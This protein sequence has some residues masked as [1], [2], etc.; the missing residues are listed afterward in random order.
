MTP[1]CPRCGRTRASDDPCISRLPGVVNACCGHGDPLV[2]PY[3][4]LAG[5]PSATVYGAAAVTLMRALGGDPPDYPDSY[6][7]VMVSTGSRSP[8]CGEEP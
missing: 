8:C 6:T 5:D 7:A 3:V 2:I 4:T 1:A